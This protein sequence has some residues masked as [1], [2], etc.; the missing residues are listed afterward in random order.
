MS[1]TIQDEVERLRGVQYA[2]EYGSS[3]RVVFAH[4]AD[5]TA[6]HSVNNLLGCTGELG[7]TQ[8]HLPSADYPLD[9]IGE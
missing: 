9:Q 2:V 4:N 7:A 3:L 5:T 8:E 1:D 6:V